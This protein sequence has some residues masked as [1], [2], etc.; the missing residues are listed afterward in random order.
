MKLGILAGIVALASI[1]S[2]CVGTSV[3]LADAP[4]AKLN[5]SRGHLVT[6]RASSL[7]LFGFIPLGVND[8]QARAYERLQANAGADCLTDIKVRDTWCWIVIGEKYGTFLTATACPYKDPSQQT[9]DERLKQLKALRDSNV[10]TQAEYEQ[11]R[12]QIIKS[13]K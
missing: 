9:V 12:D 5:L 6:G 3:H 13:I 7:H 4:I 11:A 8:R 10:I 1:G 2:G